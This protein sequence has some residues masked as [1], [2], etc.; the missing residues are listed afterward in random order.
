M[1]ADS[2]ADDVAFALIL[3][4]WCQRGTFDLRRGWVMRISFI[5]MDRA[6]RILESITF[7]FVY[8][9]KK[10]SYGSVLN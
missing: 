7:L 3:Y 9:P 5:I 1:H 6:R 10:A 2:I 8:Q 4:T